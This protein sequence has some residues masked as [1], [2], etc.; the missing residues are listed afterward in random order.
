MAGGEGSR[1]ASLE[2]RVDPGTGVSGTRCHAPFIPG[3]GY[4]IISNHPVFNGA[5]IGRAGEW[6]FKLFGG[7]VEGLDG[8][9]V[10]SVGSAI[11]GPQVFEKSL[12]CVNNLR[13]QSGRAVVRDLRI[14][15]VDLQDGGGWDWTTG[16]AAQDEPGVL[17]ALL[18]EL[19]AHGR[20]DALPAV[21]QRRVRPSSVSRVEQTRDHVEVVG[22]T[23]SVQPV[24]VPVPVPEFSTHSFQVP[25]VPLPF[26]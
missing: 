4:D 24:S 15:V 8:G 1:R 9:V 19:F 11:M 25:C 5:V 26:K 6:D 2:A 23:V 22:V 12:S 18:Q 7:S 14:F 3:I 21:R 16:R 17:P 13:L 20:G 10:L